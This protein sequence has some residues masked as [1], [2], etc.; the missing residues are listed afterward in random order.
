MAAA[1]PEPAQLFF[2][3]QFTIIPSDVLHD[4]YSLKL[5]KC[6]E[7]NGA[8]YVPI[9]AHNRV[10]DVLHHTHIISTTADFPDYN[11]A[12]EAMVHVVKPSWVDQSLAKGKQSNPRQFSPD[13]CLFF[14]D[15]VV[16]CANIPD[17]DKEAIIGGVLAMGG[18]YSASL[19]KLVT[20]IVALSLDH[21]KCELAIRKQLRS[22]IVLP[23]WFDDC[24]KLGKKLSE[25]PY[26]LPDP[27]ILRPSSNLPIRY[28]EPLEH[29]KGA[30]SP[31]AGEVPSALPS[32]SPSPR[33][34]E[35]KVFTGKKIMLSGDLQIG[36]R[37]QGTIEELIRSGGGSITASIDAADIYVCHYRD[38]HDYVEASRAE[39]D[40]GNL[41]WLYHLITHNA[42]T[43]P[44]RRLLHY[45]VPRNGIPGFEDFEISLSNYTG[46]ARVYL[47]NLVIAAGAKFT[48]TM[49]ARNTHLITA[50]MMSEKCDAAREWNVNIVNHL[51]IEESYAKCTVQSITNH[52]YTHFPART[53]LG[54]VVGQTQIDRDA[55]ESK[56]FKADPIT[57]RQKERLAAAGAPT[58]HPSNG[59]VKPKP[60]P[61][62]SKSVVPQSSSTAKSSGN[63]TD[64][65]A[66]PSPPNDDVSENTTPL[67]KKIKRVRSD[68]TAQTPAARHM[69]GKEN[70]TPGTTGSRG[71]KAR[72]L[73]KLHELAPDVARFEKE[74]KRKGGVIHGGR[75]V[76]DSDRITFG[77]PAATER[78][79]KRRS[80]E[81]EEDDSGSSKSDSDANEDARK[82][83][84]TKQGKQAKEKVPPILYRMM[85]TGDERWIDDVKESREKAQLRNLGILLTQNAS[86]ATLLCAPKLLRT[87]KFI[88]ALA[89][90]PTVVSSGFLDFILKHNRIPPAVNYQISD[91]N[92]EERFGLRLCESLDRA[93][94]NNRRLLRGWTIFVTER[95]GGGFDT[96]KEIIQLNGGV[97]QLYRGRTGVT[98]S[99]RNKNAPD[100]GAESQH[101]GNEEGDILYLVSGTDDEDVALWEKF[102]SMTRKQ[103]LVPRIAKPDWLLFVAMAQ[104][105][106]WDEKWLC[107]EE[108]VPGWMEKHGPRE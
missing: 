10:D 34:K 53:N 98:V 28:T 21:D 88:A 65:H 38:G 75:K 23:H 92:N 84:K 45:P 66:F 90:A 35:L 104:Q 94:Q 91:R 29:I 80:G 8:I 61:K 106:E 22:L 56:Y 72:A 77:E 11:K 9:S 50:H 33:R 15:V 12:L 96:Y 4:D 6:L 108:T 31:V 102:R 37:L 68:V 86:E 7:E 85:L 71:A 24:L 18:Q 87:R 47:E 27:E 58:P 99:K 95:I 20:H 39:K 17:G 1:T 46:E 13:P 30:T 62:V 101:Q 52:R 100:A 76:S 57:I 40:V 82:A 81:E 54:E 89:G 32:S 79:R 59:S 70:E 48:R 3:V 67:A 36:S 25:R 60:A 55:V 69:D 51:W 2:A 74:M 93:R 16:T 14:Q 19:T 97:C 105:I 63:G 73:D 107:K 64:A 42:W 41:P 83:K 103:D 43:N 49:N 44:M 78:G 26:I 5:Q